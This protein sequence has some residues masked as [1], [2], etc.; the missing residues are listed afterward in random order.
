MR[1]SSRLKLAHATQWAMILLF[2]LGTVFW[3]SVAVYDQSTNYGFQHSTVYEPV[4]NLANLEAWP[5]S[6]GW[7]KS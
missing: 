5:K 2:G 1:S 3:V 6:H 4:M 7:L